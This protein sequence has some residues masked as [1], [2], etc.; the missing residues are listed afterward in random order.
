MILSLHAGLAESQRVH[1]KALGFRD[2]PHGEHR[3]VESPGGLA[4]GDF[5]SAPAFPLVGM[6][7]NHFHAQPGRVAEA[8]EGLAKPL[9]DG[10]VIRLVTLEMIFPERQRSLGDRE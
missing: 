7:F 8:D 4:L 9:G 5:R 3:S 1:E 6:V 2:F 10:V